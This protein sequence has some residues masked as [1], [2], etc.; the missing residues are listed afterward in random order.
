ME[1]FHIAYASVD[2]RRIDLLESAD[3]LC[4]RNDQ[5]DSVNDRLRAQGGD[6]GRNME[7]RYNKTVDQA[8]GQAGRLI[9]VCAECNRL[10]SFCVNHVFSI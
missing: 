2:Q 7:L 1:S 4:V 10:H 5:G 9:Y 3:R 8:P 6:K